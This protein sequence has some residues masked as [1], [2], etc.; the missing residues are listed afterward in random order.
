MSYLIYLIIMLNDQKIII[1]YDKHNVSI[2]F[3]HEINSCGG[4]DKM[5]EIH[6]VNIM[7]NFYK[8]CTSKI[9]I[10]TRTNYQYRKNIIELTKQYSNIHVI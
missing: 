2:G 5:Y 1:I 7:N 3:E 10:I 9:L 6:D 8:M 4:V